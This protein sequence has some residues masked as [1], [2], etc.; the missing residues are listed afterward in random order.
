MKNQILKN[1]VV[2]AVLLLLIAHGTTRVL[3][4]GGG[5]SAGAIDA[6]DPFLS[7]PELLTEEEKKALD[8]A[9]IAMEATCCPSAPTEV[10]EAPGRVQTKE[11]ANFEAELRR[12]GRSLGGIKPSNWDTDG[13]I[14]DKLPA[15]IRRCSMRTQPQKLPKTSHGEDAQDNL[16][17]WML[18]RPD[19]DKITT[20]EKMRQDRCGDTY[21]HE[22]CKNLL[23]FQESIGDDAPSE[24]II[25]LCTGPLHANKK[26]NMKETA[27]NCFCK[28]NFLDGKKIGLVE[29][30]SYEEEAKYAAEHGAD[31]SEYPAEYSCC[32]CSNIDAILAII[33]TKKNI[34]MPDALGNTP[35]H[36]ACINGSSALVYLLLRD[37]ALNARASIAKT[38][39]AGL[40]PLACLPETVTA[41]DR[42]NINR[43]IAKWS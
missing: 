29:D 36:N 23:F 41:K 30:G 9:L 8:A 6:F 2:L 28:Y 35:L 19:L 24:G 43:E 21:L 37:E 32:E 7:P 20:E 22:A 1:K 42:E 15:P 16:D 26:N 34:T 11:E 10:S 4:A 40:T 13:T 38:N 3:G 18:D 33:K 17:D 31:D 25:E 5:S 39:H 27:L 14:L 12:T